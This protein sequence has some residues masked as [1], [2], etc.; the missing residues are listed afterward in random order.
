MK[1]RILGNSLRLRLSQSEVNAFESE[2]VVGEKIEFPNG[3][4]LIYRL[5]KSSDFRS[6]F[7]D[8][9][10]TISIPHEE[11]ESWINTNQVGIRQN[12]DLENEEKLSILVEKDFKCL[13]ER[14]E[15]ESD[16]YPNPNESH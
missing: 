9:V 16:L 1:V 14:G 3:R 7:T 2:G 8:D 12:L 11:A 10:I 5:C 6:D 13:T 15:D 4:S